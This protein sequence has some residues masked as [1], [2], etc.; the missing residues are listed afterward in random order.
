M[1]E[2][3]AA[4]CTVRW[5]R[6]SGATS[7]GSVSRVMGPKRTSVTAILTKL[8]AAQH[9][10]AVPAHER[11]VTAQADQCAVRGQAR[12]RAVP[13]QAHEHAVAGS[14]PRA[15]GVRPMS[16]WLWPVPLRNGRRIGSSTVS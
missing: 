16:V 11:A 15:C 8:P 10:H 2:D 3:R 7:P 5:G 6:T 13:C 12:E 9:I 14:G 1:N 4:G